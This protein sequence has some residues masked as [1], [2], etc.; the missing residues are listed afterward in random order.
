MSK[1][2]IFPG[3][4]D[5]ITKGHVEVVETAV[6]L[7]DEVIVAVAMSARK[8]PHFELKDRLAMCKQA[9][10]DF[11]KITVKSFENLIVS[12]AKKEG[13]QFLLR[14]IRSVSDFDYEFQMAG[15]NYLMSPE[16]ETLFLPAKSENAYISG[17]MIREILSLGGD[18]S[19]FLPE[20]VAEYLR[21]H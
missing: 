21:H 7:F 15:M 4:F 1:I 10:S 12:F 18:A 13:A 2:A 11:D 9:L 19:T 14:G 8:A 3:T 17:T 6:K 20:G 5:P 16:L